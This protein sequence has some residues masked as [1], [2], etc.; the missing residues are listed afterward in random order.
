MLVNKAYHNKIVH[1]LFPGNHPENSGHPQ[2]A[3]DVLFWSAS[4]QR[5]IQR[6]GALAPPWY[7]C[8]PRQR[9]IWAASTKRGVEVREE[10]YA[11]F[12]SARQCPSFS[13]AC[14]MS[15]C[16]NINKD[17]SDGYFLN[18]RSVSPFLSNWLDI[19]DPHDLTCQSWKRLKCLLPHSL[20]NGEWHLVWPEV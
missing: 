13:A 20:Q 16:S 18:K 19:W 4:Q 1:S 10:D 11:S 8:V 9:K 17:I 14:I 2:S 15:S 7:G 12:I 3:L 6:P 5:P